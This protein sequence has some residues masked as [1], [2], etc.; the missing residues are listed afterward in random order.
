MFAFLRRLYRSMLPERLRIMLRPLLGRVFRARPIKSDKALAKRQKEP[1][2]PADQQVAHKPAD[3]QV[4][5]KPVDQQV[6]QTPQP[7]TPS[8][9][10][11]LE[12]LLNRAEQNAARDPDEAIRSC[13]TILGTDGDVPRAYTIMGKAFRAKGD[14]KEYDR[15]VIVAR[16]RGLALIA[17]G[18]A[19]RAAAFFDAV[20][21]EFPIQ[22]EQLLA[23]KRLEDLVQLVAQKAMHEPDETIRFCWAAIGNDEYMSSAYAVMGKALRAK[24]DQKEYDR[25]VIVARDKGLALFARGEAARAAA[26]FDAIADEFP[27]QPEQLLAQKRLEDLVQLVAQKAMHEPDETI[28]FCWAAIGNDE[29]MSSA[30]AVMGKALRIKGDHKEYDRIAILVRDK[31]LA[32]IGRGELA[33]GAAF[34]FRAAKEFFD[35]CHGYAL[36]Y[37][38]LDE[39]TNAYR[40]QAMPSTSNAGRRRLIIAFAVWGDRYIDLLTRYFIPSIL[41]PN[42]LPELSRIRDV[43]L[44]IYTPPNFIPAIKVSA[45][46]RQLL[47]YAKV[48]FIEFPLEIITQPEYTR[49]P[50]Y[51]YYI[52][53]GFHHLSIE[54]ARAINA[55]VICI[56]PD[57]VHSDGA[58]TNY[59]RFVDQGYKAVLFTSMRGQAETLAPILDSMRD[60]DTQSLTLPSRTLV[61]LSA[62]HVHHNFKRF[63]LTKGNRGIPPGLSLMF[64]PNSHG[65]YIRCFHIHPIILA[66]DAIK[67]NIAFDYFTVDSNSLLRMFPTPGSWKDVKVIQDS[68]DGIMLDLTYTYEEETYPECEFA[69]QQLLRQLPGYRANHFWHFSHRIVYHTDEVIDAIGTFDR[70]PDGS[71]ERKFLPVSS[72]I[73]IKDD[74]LAAWFEANRPKSS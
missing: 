57:G 16:D 70:K 47:R 49:F 19:A 73:D 40:A 2:N 55:D 21:E 42:N 27:I 34:F 7:E 15:V 3:Q 69:P 72:A 13:W 26:F 67:N 68:D 63:I 12:Q 50:A 46:Y 60:E 14:Q 56:A 10:E 20:A 4:A 74:E 24:G 65:F 33:R 6:A 54:H 58:F 5:H 38:Q 23:Q 30:Y 37:R 43:S 11:T 36:L 25:V 35:V 44:D 39:M 48:D 61:A 17:R 41:S 29:Y 64:F 28:R 9:L 62:A 52:Y 31:G 18:E 66:A 53:G 71:I 45:S 51:R 32:L 1:V 8:A 59:A 22:P